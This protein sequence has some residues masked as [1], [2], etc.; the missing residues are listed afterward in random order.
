MP[1]N[2]YRTWLPR[3]KCRDK[4]ELRIEPLIREGREVSR[5][6]LHRPAC[7]LDLPQPAELRPAAERPGKSAEGKSPYPR[8]STWL[9][10]AYTERQAK[11]ACGRGGPAS[12]YGICVF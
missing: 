2:R 8:E 9:G 3:P 10:L 6:G 12:G 5:F 1:I 4:K 11:A 7:P